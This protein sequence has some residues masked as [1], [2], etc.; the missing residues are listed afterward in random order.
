MA[1]ADQVC[2]SD[3]RIGGLLFTRPVECVDIQADG[4]G[5]DFSDDT[6]AIFHGIEQIGF[7][8]VEIFDNKGHAGLLRN[9]G[10]G[11]Y[12]FG[13]L[14]E[15]AIERHIRRSL[16]CPSATEA[17]GFDVQP[18]GALKNRSR[19]LNGRF[20]ICVRSKE[21]QRFRNEFDKVPN[22]QWQGPDFGDS[23]F[24]NVR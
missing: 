23:R 10:D 3:N 9:R 8:F 11:R 21:G 22:G 13:N 18:T 17:D 4:I 1:V 16:A 24:E 7:V 19:S 15:C 20:H 5:A 6:S 14:V 12:E 2:V